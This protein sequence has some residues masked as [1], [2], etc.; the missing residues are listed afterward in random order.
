MNAGGRQ[1]AISGLAVHGQQLGLLRQ[2][3][4]QSKRRRFKQRPPGNAEDTEVELLLGRAT[5]PRSTSS[6][7]QE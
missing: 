6:K 1:D 3:D 5:P 7:N 2:P 4:P